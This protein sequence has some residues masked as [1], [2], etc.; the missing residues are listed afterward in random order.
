[1]Y[2]ITK[3]KQARRINLLIQETLQRLIGLLMSV[4]KP[5]K[6][7]CQRRGLGQCSGGNQPH[8]RST[9][10]RLGKCVVCYKV[11]FVNPFIMGHLPYINFH[12]QKTMYLL[13]RYNKNNGS[14]NA[15]EY[16]W[17]SS[18]SHI[19]SSNKRTYNPRP[20]P[21]ANLIITII[22]LTLSPQ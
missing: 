21:T 8:M 9:H 4:A 5:L 13:L 19:P 14:T 3:A 22:P 1:M 17:K 12:I 2:T 15:L 20:S 11:S 16:C 6:G 10:A 7:F 18:Y